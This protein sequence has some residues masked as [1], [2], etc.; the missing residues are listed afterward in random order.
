V[1]R[2]IVEQNASSRAAAISPPPNPRSRAQAEGWE[3]TVVIVYDGTGR[4]TAR[5][6]ISAGLVNA[7]R[8]SVRPW[9]LGLDDTRVADL[10]VGGDGVIDRGGATAV[11]DGH[12]VPC[13]QLL[14]LVLD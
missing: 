11:G 2:T 8:G 6:D 14:A 1:G 9:D 10:V 4:S 13:E 3:R 5:R 12:A 7:S